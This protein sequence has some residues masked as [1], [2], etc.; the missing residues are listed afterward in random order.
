MWSWSWAWGLKSSFVVL[1]HSVAE[2]RRLW[3]EVRISCP[4]SEISALMSG[5]RSQALIPSLWWL[6]AS[7]LK[8]RFTVLGHWDALLWIIW[9]VLTLRS[10]VCL[11]LVL[12]IMVFILKSQVW[13]HASRSLRCSIMRACD[14]TSESHVLNLEFQILYL[15]SDH[16]PRSHVSGHGCDP[17]VSNLDACS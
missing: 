13:L 16:T 6:W 11:S 2:L 15:S 7:G 14:L 10:Q 9:Y 8:S 4:T 17:K 12:V 1:A 3:V 5:R